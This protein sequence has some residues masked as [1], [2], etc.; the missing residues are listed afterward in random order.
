MKT[1]LGRRTKVLLR[2]I[3]IN[4]GRLNQS[5]NTVQT[6]LVRNKTP[7]S[8]RRLCIVTYHISEGITCSH[9]RVGPT[10]SVQSRYHNPNRVQPLL[11]SRHW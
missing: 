9:V 6:S 1:Y 11:T 4:N 8:M 7:C 2:D 3:C 10:F 5:D